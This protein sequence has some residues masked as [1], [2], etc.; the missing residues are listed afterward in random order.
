[1]NAFLYQICPFSIKKRYGDLKAYYVLFMHHHLAMN[2]YPLIQDLTL[3]ISY[4]DS[5][6][7]ILFRLRVSLNV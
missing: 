4:S 3:F 2:F 5:F 1:M 6:V 7:M